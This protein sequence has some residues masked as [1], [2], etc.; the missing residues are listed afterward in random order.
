MHASNGKRF[1]SCCVH[2]TGRAGRAGRAGEAITF[3]TE[4]DVPYL[5]NIAN[6]M[7]ESGCEVPS[8]IMSMPK[9]KWKKYRPMR[10]SISCVP[11]DAN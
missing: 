9:A 7:S 10:D 3:Y 6:V 5:R 2:F 11:N 8:W 1:D 4:G